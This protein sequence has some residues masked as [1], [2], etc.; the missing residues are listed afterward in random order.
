MR[1]GYAEVSTLPDIAPADFEALVASRQL[2]LAN[3]LLGSSTAKWREMAGTYL[4]RTVNRLRH[5][6]D[7]GHFTRVLPTT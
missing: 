5:W 3:L 6:L 2:F 4:P 1:T 7:S